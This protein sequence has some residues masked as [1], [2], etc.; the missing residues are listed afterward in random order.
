MSSLWRTRTWTRNTH[1]N[2]SSC[3][4][5]CPKKVVYFCQNP[6]ALKHSIYLELPPSI[7]YNVHS[8]RGRAQ[9]T[10]NHTPLKYWPVCL[11]CPCIK[12]TER[13]RRTIGQR[14]MRRCNLG[15][16]GVWGVRVL[17]DAPLGVCLVRQSSLH[18]VQRWS[19]MSYA[20]WWRATEKKPTSNLVTIVLSWYL[21][22]LSVIILVSIHPSIHPSLPVSTCVCVC[23]CEEEA[24]TDKCVCVC[25]CFSMRAWVPHFVAP[26][27]HTLLW[28]GGVC[29]SFKW[30]TRHMCGH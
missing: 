5:S 21:F 2:P 20:V 30:A 23:V 11:L 17:S 27:P 18:S 8:V 9:Q 7:N 14:E 13:K 6:K 19:L 1:F 25:V 29:F 12:R 24:V 15:I 10:P 4:I 26:R 28:P 3:H 22:A 16:G